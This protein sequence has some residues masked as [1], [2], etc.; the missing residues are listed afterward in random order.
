MQ[1]RERDLKEYKQ[2]HSAHLKDTSCDVSKHSAREK[3][4]AEIAEKYG[5]DSNT[6]F[7]RVVNK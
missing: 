6:F 1:V 2:I 5:M 7:W 4:M 3:R